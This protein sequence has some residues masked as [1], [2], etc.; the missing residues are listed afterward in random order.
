MLYSGSRIVVFYGSNSWAY[1]RL[2][3]VQ[4]LSAS[5]LDGLLGNG[6]V[7]LTLYTED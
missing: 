5:E 2:G 1:T 4:G 3:R 6:A 7:S